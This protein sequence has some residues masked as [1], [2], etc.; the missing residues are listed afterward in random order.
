MKPLTAEQKLAKIK[1][2][3]EARRQTHGGTLLST[4]AAFN[5]EAAIEDIGHDAGR[6]DKVTMRTLN[7]VA[8]QLGRISQI[9]ELD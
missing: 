3:F 7:R 8:K 9:L 4:H 1:R 5:L 2:A 6:C